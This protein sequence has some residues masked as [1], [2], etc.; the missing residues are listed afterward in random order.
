MDADP[1]GVFQ[2]RAQ[3]SSRRKLFRIARQV[4]VQILAVFIDRTCADAL[5]YVLPKG[6]KAFER[7]VYRPRFGRFG[8]YA[9]HRG[10]EARNLYQDERDRYARY[11]EYYERDADHDLRSFVCDRRGDRHLRG[12]QIR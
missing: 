8:V 2:D 5:L 1:S 12:F 10:F 11:G 4:H 3:G 9:V 6:Q 7:A